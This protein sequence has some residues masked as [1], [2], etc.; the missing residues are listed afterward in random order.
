M[1]T[2]HPV[3]LFPALEQIGAA[4]SRLIR[5]SSG[6]TVLTEGKCYCRD[7][8]FPSDLPKYVIEVDETL[9]LV[10]KN[11]RYLA[12]KHLHFGIATIVTGHSP[13]MTQTD[14]NIR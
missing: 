7:N 5:V 3:G 12:E 10:A 14:H 11:I 13:D 4:V 9:D 1:L 2:A 8:P 6:V